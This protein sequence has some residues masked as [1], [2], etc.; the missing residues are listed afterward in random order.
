MLDAKQIHSLPRIHSPVLTAYLDTNPANP[1]N[2]GHPPGY[3]IYLKSRGKIIAERAPKEEQKLVR[4]QLKLVE[5]YLRNHPP[6]SRGLLL[7]A[8]PRAWEVLPLQVEVEDELHWGR[9]SLTQLLWLLDEHQ[10]CG[11]AFVD[12]SG[13]RFFR[14]WMGEAEEH[15]AAAFKVDTTKWRQ[16]H[17]M[18]PAHPGLHKTRGSQRDVFEQ[19][20]EAQYAKFYRDAAERIRLWAERETLDPVFIAGPNEVVEPVWAELPK[21][22]REGAAMLKGDLSHASLAELHARLEP[23]IAV[24]KRGAELKIVE[25]MLGSSNGTRAVVGMDETLAQLQMGGARELVVARGLGGK[26]K[27]CARCGW[28][29]RS[30][31]PACGACGGERRAVALRAVFPELAR[32]YGVPVE[33]VAGEAGRKLRQA[34]GIG[35]WLR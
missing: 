31:D 35:A 27:Q 1:R 34:G 25:K 26:M 10:P 24:W 7:V 3:V 16:K 22:F 5:E 8:G 30:A 23:E 12:R 6:R 2:Q 32:K 17:L 21:P 14:F 19:R 13:A 4:E 33:V 9:P 29:D 18:P 15:A 11:V 20:V 28:V